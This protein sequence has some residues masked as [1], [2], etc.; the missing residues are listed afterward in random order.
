MGGALVD[1]DTE[2]RLPIIFVRCVCVEVFVNVHVGVGVD[3][4]HNRSIEEM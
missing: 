3:H 2:C 4:F 1:L